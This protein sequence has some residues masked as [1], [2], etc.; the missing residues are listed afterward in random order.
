LW[1]Y[2]KI[3]QL[4]NRKQTRNFKL[5]RR[6]GN[7][8]SMTSFPTLEKVV[9]AICG[10]NESDLFLLGRDLIHQL[11]GEFSVVRCRNCGL[12][13]TNP[14][15]STS[16]I[17]MYYPDDYGPHLH[18]R[19]KDGLPLNAALFGKRFKNWVSLIIRNL[20]NSGSTNL[21]SFPSPG[22]MLEVGCATGR[23]LSLMRDKGWETWGLEFAQKPATYAREVLGLNVTQCKAEEMEF[24]EECFDLVVAWMVIEH[25]HDPVGVL[26]AIRKTLKKDGYFTFSIPNAEAWEIKYFKRYWYGLHLPNHLYHFTPV[27]IS[28]TLKKA[29][30]RMEKLVF[31]RCMRNVMASLGFFLRDRLGNTKLTN[32]LIRYPEEATWYTHLSLMPIATLI[33]M[34][35]QSGRITIWARKV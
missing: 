3:K 5:K 9:C 6:T 35:K 26:T 7:K 16:S 27:T 22:K 23:F 8:D 4:K 21:P 34:F 32:T 18:V 28:E 19:E 12:L 20:L 13:Y 10:S 31:Q 25:L 33:A 11:P 14:R 29:G 17:S 1:T 15:P 30:L 2:P 24:P